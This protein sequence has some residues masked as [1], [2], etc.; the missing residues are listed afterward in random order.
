MAGAVPR[1]LLVRR[2]QMTV[3]ISDALL[4]MRLP[5]LR[6][7]TGEV[8]PEVVLPRGRYAQIEIDRDHK[9]PCMELSE[10]QKRRVEADEVVMS[11]FLPRGTKKPAYHWASEMPLR[12]R[13]SGDR[14]NQ[15]EKEVAMLRNELKKAGIVVPA[16]APVP[17]EPVS[18]ADEGLLDPLS[19]D[20]S[21]DDVIKGGAEIKV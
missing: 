13:G 20:A 5:P 17:A 3:I 14:I 15:L 12:W 18:K 6:L 21:L 4:E 11:M 19:F 16:A 2:N 7:S 1:P 8:L 9:R 10:A